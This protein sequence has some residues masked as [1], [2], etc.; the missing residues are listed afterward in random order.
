MADV[1][2]DVGPVGAAIFDKPYVAA[3]VMDYEKD[4]TKKLRNSIRPKDRANCVG[5]RLSTQADRTGS[6]RAARWW[7]QL[8]SA[9]FLHSSLNAG[10]IVRDFVDRFLDRL[11]VGMDFSENRVLLFR[12]FF[13]SFGLFSQLIEHGILSAGNSVHPPEAYTPAGNVRDRQKVV[14]K[15]WHI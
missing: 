7:H 3:M 6:G 11:D 1:C 12:N 5:E 8:K 9:L 2:A 13:D 10:H 14:I 15:A 4:I